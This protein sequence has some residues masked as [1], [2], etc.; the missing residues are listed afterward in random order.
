MKTSYVKI[1]AIILFI[2]ISLA[3]VVHLYNFVGN[4]F[5]NEM[6][7]GLSAIATTV[8][9]IGGLALL[10]VTYISYTEVRRQRVAMEEPA[11]TVKVMPDK[12]SLG[13]LNLE[14]KNTGGGQ[15]YDVNVVFDP[16]I[17][18][19]DMSLNKLNIFQ[20][21]ALLEKGEEISFFFNTIDQYKKS[22]SP[23]KSNVLISYYT[24]PKESRGAKK[25]VRSY[26]IDFAERYGLSHLVKRNMDDLVDQ[27][28]DLKH[29]LAAIHS[30][31]RN[32]ND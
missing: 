23:M 17:P 7:S 27:V 30:E 15:A 21:T 29:V 22:N 6:L 9:A 26:E 18:Y 24:A 31:S 16:D 3:I 14:L 5:D 10:I 28:E 2:C 8:A 11:V 1:A 19:R 32:K 13:C 4:D 20:R 25:I 12:E